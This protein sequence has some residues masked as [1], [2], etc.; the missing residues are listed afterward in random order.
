MK[1]ALNT[2]VIFS[3]IFTLSLNAYSL[4]LGYNKVGKSLTEQISNG[5]LNVVISQN[6]EKGNYQLVPSNGYKKY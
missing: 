1:N 3:L 6:N 2:I 5:N 4:S